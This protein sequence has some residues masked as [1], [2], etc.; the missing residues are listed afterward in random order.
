LPD[1]GRSVDKFDAV[2]KALQLQEL[3]DWHPQAVFAPEF[4]PYAAKPARQCREASPK[5]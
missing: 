2:H 1:A 5:Q 4:K 3:N